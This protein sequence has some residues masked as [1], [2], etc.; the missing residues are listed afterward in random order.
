MPSHEILRFAQD[1][2]GTALH[3]LNLE[4]VEVLNHEGNFAWGVADIPVKLDLSRL[5][6]PK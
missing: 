3:D 1:D 6:G 5:G 4:H 2:S